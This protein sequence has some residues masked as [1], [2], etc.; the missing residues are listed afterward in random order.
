VEFA[1]SALLEVQY[2]NGAWPQR[3]IAAPD[4]AKF[5]VKKAGYPDSW[6]WTYPGR[7]YKSFYTFNDNTIADT[8]ATMLEAFDI[9]GEAR[10]QAS[11]EKAGDFILLAQMPEPQP[12]WAQQY[13]ADM[14]PAWARKFEP[15][16]VTGGE[17]H[18]VMKTL[19]VLYRATGKK[20]YLEPLPRAI[21]YLR[22]SR[23]PDG[24]LA[25]FY[26]LKT[27]KPLYFTR[28]DY[29]LTYSDADM[30]THYSFKASYGV[31]SIAQEYERLRA[32]DPVELKRSKK[33][34]RPRLN[35]SL[36]ARAKSVIDRLDEK[37]RWV[38]DGQLRNDGEDNPTRRVIDCR[39]FI[40]NIR[41]LSTYL[42]A[43]R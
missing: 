1:L 28:E 27:N 9:Y 40:S 24:R 14:H 21:E 36:A 34:S 25:R 7:D 5:P 31:E 2:P 43:V 37:G 15:P 23:L 38:E 32:M 33:V 8:M 20:K 35:R 19:L 4:P 17:S 16:A 41:T 42:T 12:A 26:E 39:T 30:P 11:A 18:G 3:F 22:R 10:Y 6:S 13:D 29:K